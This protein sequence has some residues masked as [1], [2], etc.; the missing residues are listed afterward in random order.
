[1]TML[2]AAELAALRAD[3][4][5]LL[6]DTC[7]IQRNSGTVDVYGH[8]S[9][10]WSNAGTSICRFDP[11][12]HAGAGELAEREAMRNYYRL[13]VTYDADLR[14][15]DRVSF[16]SDL[17]EVVELHDDHSLRA[18]RRAIVSKIE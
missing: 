5:N 12:G 16:S 2:T 9:E 17:Y 1:M 11:F 10:A 7:I 18:V 15:G 13:T 4:A 6:P 14:P 8:V 3:M